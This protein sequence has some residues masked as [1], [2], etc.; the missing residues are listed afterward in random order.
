MAQHV[1]ETDPKL[2]L[3]KKKSL[4]VKI[5]A[6]KAANRPPNEPTKAQHTLQMAQHVPETDPKIQPQPN[7]ASVELEILAPK[8]ANRTP[9]SLT[10]AQQKS[11]KMPFQANHWVLA[12]GNPVHFRNPDVKKTSYMQ[13]MIYK[14]IWIDISYLFIHI[15]IYICI[16][17]YAH[18]SSHPQWMLDLDGWEQI[19][20]SKAHIVKTL[21]LPWLTPIFPSPCA[22]D[23]RLFAARLGN[24][25]NDCTNAACKHWGSGQKLHPTQDQD[26][27]RWLDI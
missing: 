9:N 22:T 27:S 23:C 8:A 7:H 25:D 11:P 19:F 6:P 18:I 10:K 15:Y 1:P 20:H 13:K 12:F 14:Q 24:F 5:L 17:I 3:N 26:L 2:T 21:G 4:G 16:R